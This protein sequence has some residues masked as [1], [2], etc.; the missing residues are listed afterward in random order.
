MADSAGPPRVSIVIPVHNER[1]A[2][3]TLYQRLAAALGTEGP[4]ELLFVDDGSA[5]GSTDWLRDLARRD[6][7][8]TVV[9]LTR[10]WGQLAATLCGLARASGR[11]LVTLDADLAHPPEAVPAL[12]RALRV[13]HDVV[14]GVREGG[15]R[16]SLW[17]TLSRALLRWVFGVRV[18]EDLSTFRAFTAEFVRRLPKA[19]EGV[20]LLGAEIRRLGARIGYVPVAVGRREGGRSKYGGGRKFL[21]ALAAVATYGALPW[22]VLL[23]PLARWL[24]R[25][26]GSSYAVSEVISAAGG[27]TGV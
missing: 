26:A 2:L 12:L 8:V 14:V 13:G 6:H 1:P 19:G 22:R 5:D 7:A 10:R 17:S 16:S 18:P 27:H 25:A 15:G 4:Y 11:E 3:P 23:R 24:G 21:V 9:V 20:V